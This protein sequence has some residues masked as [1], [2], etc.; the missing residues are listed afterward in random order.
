M[1][2]PRSFHLG[3]PMLLIS[4]LYAIASADQWQPKCAVIVDVSS[5]PSGNAIATLVEAKL[6]EQNIRLVD[7]QTIDR[8]LP[9]QYLSKTGLVDAQHAVQ[10]GKL[11]S[12][13]LLAFVSTSPDGSAL[14]VF[15]AGTGARL[16]DEAATAVETALADEF[17]RGIV[18]AIQKRTRERGGGAAG[19]RTVCLQ[20]VRNADLPLGKQSVARA[21]GEILMRRLAAS[22]DV[23]VLER[24]RLN[25]VTQ[26]R[27]LTG[28]DEALIAS[29][30]SIELQIARSAGNSGIDVSAVLDY[31]KGERKAVPAVQVG[32][33]NPDDIA[34]AILPGISEMLAVTRPSPS[35]A[36]EREAES[37][38]FAREAMLQWSHQEV[39]G[40]LDAAQAAYAMNPGDFHCGAL[41]ARALV[42]SGLAQVCYGDFADPALSP[43]PYMKEHPDALMP[44]LQLVGEACDALETLEVGASAVAA[45]S[46][47]AALRLMTPLDRD[48]LGVNAQT[49][50][51]RYLCAL[52]SEMPKGTA[53]WTGISPYITGPDQTALLKQIRQ[54]FRHRRFDLEREYAR[55][56]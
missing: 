49:L 52:R 39:D 5:A 51:R 19:L 10:T 22:A 55:S 1:S 6:S 35:T 47:P 3:L 23:A 54:R 46:G 41:R 32:S 53:S 13:D 37:K 31:G 40:A 33:E 14:T 11:L 50:L 8:I 43:Q 7:R 30:V 34:R 12:A 56:S 36:A 42:V 29:T 45:A 15:D 27:E 28:V 24:K 20:T 4:A 26:E 21:A 16:E 44:S 38:R 18:R 25:H 48:P 9:E 2:I 17:A